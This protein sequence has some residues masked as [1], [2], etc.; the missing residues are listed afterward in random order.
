MS[1]RSSRQSMF[2]RYPAL[3]FIVAAGAL[4]VLLPTALNVPTSGPSTLAEFAPVPGKGQGDSDLADLGAASSGGLGFGSGSG[5]AGGGGAALQAPPSQKKPRLK[6]CVGNPP[7]QTE[8][9]RSPPCVAFFEGDNGGATTRGVT[10]DE[11]TVV[12]HFGNVLG[13]AN[14]RPAGFNDLAGPITEQDPDVERHAKAFAKYFND[15]YQTYDRYVHFWGFRT[16]AASSDQVGYRASVS[17][18]ESEKKPFAL[19]PS[20]DLAAVIA[21]EA[22][23]RKIFGVTYGAF[24]RADYQ[25]SPPYLVTFSPDLED[26]A[27]SLSGY[28]CTKLVGRRARHAPDPTYQQRTREFGVF[29]SSDSSKPQS[30]QLKDML[31]GELQS[32]CGIN[33]KIEVPVV[34]G[35]NYTSPATSMRSADVTTVITLYGGGFSTNMSIHAGAQKWY[36]EWIVGANVESASNDVATSGWLHDPTVW[37]GAFGITYDYRRDSIANQTWYAAYREACSSC[38]GGSSPTAR[39]YDEFALLFYGI[40]AAGPKLTPAN[41]DKGMHAIPQRGSP[42]PYRPAAYFSPGNYSFI[43]DAMEIWWDG[44][45]PP[46]GDTHPGCYRIPNDGLRFRAKDWSGDDSQLFNPASGPCQ[47]VSQPPAG[48]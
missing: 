16:S 38:G 11:V 20:H 36:P 26:Q 47:G 3:I 27:A 39:L 43:K 31:R 19:I 8:D 40:Q 48:G 4:A 34:V 21:D 7:R 24:R 10:K 18:I 45:S 29:Y 28:I 32:R 30:A 6:R 42:D 25:K 1:K 9:P 13:G 22:A 17:Q 5:S 14:P 41:L 2:R 44:V 15:R 12:I 35:P 23:A 37:K 46:P 33:P